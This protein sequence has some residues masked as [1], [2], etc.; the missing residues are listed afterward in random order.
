MGFNCVVKKYHIKASVTI[1]AFGRGNQIIPWQGVYVFTNTVL[2]ND[3]NIYCCD[4][5]MIN[6]N[7]GK[8]NTHFGKINT[9]GL[10]CHKIRQKWWF[11]QKV[12]FLYISLC[13]L[14]H[15]CAN[16]GR[17]VRIMFPNTYQQIYIQHTFLP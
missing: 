3:R 8:E 17:K 13:F 5:N 15:C 4:E 6:T 14:P 2:Q 1:M 9:P 11:T 12:A 10:G 7:I 16:I